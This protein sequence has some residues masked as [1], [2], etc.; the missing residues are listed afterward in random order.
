MH[1]SKQQKHDLLFYIG[2]N[3]VIA[4]IIGVSVWFAWPIV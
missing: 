2:M 1:S 4:V 3:S